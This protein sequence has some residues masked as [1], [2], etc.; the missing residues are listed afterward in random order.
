MRDQ[1]LKLNQQSPSTRLRAS[2]RAL[3]ACGLAAL[4]LSTILGATGCRTTYGASTASWTQAQAVQL[5]KAGDRL[6]VPVRTEAMVQFAQFGSTIFAAPAANLETVSAA[7]YA[8]GVDLG[9][10]YI[11]TPGDAAAGGSA[12]KDFYKIRAFASGAPAAG[13]VEGRVQLIDAGGR[14]VSEL[15]AT[16]EFQAPQA[17]SNERSLVLLSGQPTDAPALANGA[18]QVLV[19]ENWINTKVRIKFGHPIIVYNAA[20]LKKPGPGPIAERQ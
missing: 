8:E 4:A 10:A 3:R 9:V 14:A 19:T 6:N 11:D 2:A 20:T 5:Q 15:P 1:K 7:R 16:I 13:R 18:T 12:L 17:S